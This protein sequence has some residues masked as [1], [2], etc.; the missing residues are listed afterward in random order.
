M[1][2]FNSHLAISSCVKSLTTAQ[3]HETTLLNDAPAPLMA[4]C[5]LKSSNLKTL[6]P[7]ISSFRQKSYHA[8][9]SSMHCTYL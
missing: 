3:N 4:V 6:V 7:H 8:M 9:D 5:D 1:S 2:H